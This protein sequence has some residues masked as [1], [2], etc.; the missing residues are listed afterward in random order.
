[1]TLAEV[2]EL[3]ASKRLVQK[4]IHLR[5]VRAHLIKRLSQLRKQRR[6]HTCH[7]NRQ[8]IAHDASGQHQEA[9]TRVGTVDAA[10]RVSPALDTGTQASWEVFLEE[11]AVLNARNEELA[12]LDAQ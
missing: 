6:R 5:A 2:E 1:M 10:T 3:S 9:P 8:S 7:C 4:R 12:Q 11:T